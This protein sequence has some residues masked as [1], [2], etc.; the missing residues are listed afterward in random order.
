LL[1]LQKKDVI[2]V[3]FK[4]EVPL[5][6]GLYSTAVENGL[7]SKDLYNDVKLFK[8]KVTRVWTG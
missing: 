3:F 2:K 8:A 7:S 1:L 6:V 5:L 4:T